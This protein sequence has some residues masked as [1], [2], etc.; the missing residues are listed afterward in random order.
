MIG[1]QVANVSHA[2]MD[3]GAFL[4]VSFSFLAHN[5]RELSGPIHQHTNSKPAEAGSAS[6][7]GREK[8]SPTD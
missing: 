3:F 7:G 8:S 5:G 2:I 4:W 1:L 6:A